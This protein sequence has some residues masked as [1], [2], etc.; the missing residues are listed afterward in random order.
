MPGIRLIA[1][2]VIAVASAHAQR[3]ELQ[4]YDDGQIEHPFFSYVFDFDQDC[5]RRIEQ[6]AMLKGLALHLVPNSVVVTF[7]SAPG[8]VIESVSIT[9]LDYEGG[10]VGTSPT[11]AVIARGRSGDFIVLHASAIGVVENLSADRHSIGQLTG[12]PIG[13]I[14][15]I[16]LQAANEGNDIF[17]D[18]IGGYFDDLSAVV[19]DAC[20]GD[21]DADR[22]VDLSDLATL[23]A[24]FGQS[25][26]TF[27][28]GDLNADG[29]VDLSDLSAMLSAFGQTCS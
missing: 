6:H 1:I 2:A 27:E 11:S 8:E 15:E 24:H 22:D 5:C 4:D 25:G 18:E 10:F 17:L 28:D 14:V 19:L 9:V 16:D 3:T 23:L 26:A 12:K 13:P 21:L 7:Q 20:P 29:N